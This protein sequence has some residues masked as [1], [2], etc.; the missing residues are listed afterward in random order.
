MREINN[1]NKGD[2][3]ARDTSLFD[4]V[5]NDYFKFF[6]KGNADAKKVVD[7]LEFEKKDISEAANIPLASVRYD[8]KMPKELKER[9]FEWANAINLVGSYFDDKEKTILWFKISNPLLG[10][11]SPKDMI[12][13]GRYK[14]L[15]RFIQNSLSE[16]KK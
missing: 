5:P 6:K 12:R 10:N 16:N 7:F 11:I 9:L 13:I 1:Y 2:M 14:K 8:T 15:I 4:T 3:E